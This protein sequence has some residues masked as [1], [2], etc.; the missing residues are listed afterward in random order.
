MTIALFLPN[1]YVLTH[2]NSERGRGLQSHYNL[3]DVITN[4]SINA[5]KSC[6]A[7]VVIIRTYYFI[8]ALE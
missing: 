3:A 7:T 5:L 6:L 4:D 8:A 2:Q 1:T